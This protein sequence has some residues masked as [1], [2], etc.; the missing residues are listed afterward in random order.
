MVNL[1]KKT[2]FHTAAF[3][4]LVNHMAKV[5]TPDA[6]IDFA[7]MRDAQKLVGRGCHVQ[8][9]GF[10]VGEKR[11]RYPDIFQILRTDHDAFYSR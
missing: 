8:V 1:K 2:L 9:T 10:L 4:F 5:Y 6:A 7:Q 11:V 3:A